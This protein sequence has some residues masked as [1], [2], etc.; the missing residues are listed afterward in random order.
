MSSFESKFDAFSMSSNKYN[1]YH[2][3]LCLLCAIPCVPWV[4]C[5]FPRVLVAS[6]DET[7]ESHLSKWES[8][9]N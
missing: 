3:V 2:C 4:P 7:H 5:D 1:E 9:A 8:W 6:Y